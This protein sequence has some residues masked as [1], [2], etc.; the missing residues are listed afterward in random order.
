VNGG[1]P[2]S[3]ALNQDFRVYGAPLWAPDETRVLFYGVRSRDQS[4]APSWWIARLAASDAT[5]VHLAGAESNDL[6]SSAARA[7][8]R[9]GNRESI[10]YSAASRESWKFWRVGISPRGVIDEKPELVAYGSGFLDDDGSVSDDGKL[11]YT[12]S[13]GALSIYQ[14]PIDD[15]GQKLGPTLQLPLPES[16]AHGSPSVSRDGIWMTYNTSLPGDQAI[17]IRLRNLIT[18]ADH[19]LD[20]KDRKGFSNGETSISP[21]GSKVIFGRDCKRGVWPDH[22]DAPLPCGFIVAA[23][24]GEPEQVCER[25]TPRGWSADGSVVLFQKYDL[26]DV[27]KD[28]IVAVDLR[29]KTE[30]DFLSL[31][32]RPLFHPFFSWDGKWVVFKKQSLELL[33]PSQ[34]L[35]APVRNGLPAGREEWIAVTDGQHSDDKPQFSADGNKVYFTSTRDGFLCIWVQRLDPITKHPLEPP[36]AFEHFHNTAGRSAASIQQW[37]DLSVGRDKI[38]INLPQVQSDIWM[39]QIQ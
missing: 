1:G 32:D 2:V 21:D 34:I 36:F 8:V 23:S 6:P 37:P 11:V 35:I 20:D 3:L 5:P 12:L 15:S 10:V 9:A 25:C 4:K 17:T 19:L 16:G 33:P 31:P 7:W 14:I 27:N 26:T 28:R 24:G 22:P 38:L 18:G 13:S 29:T 39:T 30:R